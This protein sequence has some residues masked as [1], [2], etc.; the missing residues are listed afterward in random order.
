MRAK[1]KTDAENESL[2][3]FATNLKDLFLSPPYRGKVV[4]GIDPGFKHGCKVAIVDTTGEVLSLNKIFLPR[5]GSLNVDS[6]AARTLRS[7]LLEFR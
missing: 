1:L 3:I 2:P 6:T 4:M 7:L 5:E